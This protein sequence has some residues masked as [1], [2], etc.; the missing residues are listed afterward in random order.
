M[1][2]RALPI[3]NENCLKDVNMKYLQQKLTS[4][5]LKERLIFAILLFLIL[6]FCIVA[7]SYLL[8]P[9]GI[10]KSKNPLS[11]W[12]TSDNTVI[13]TLQI[14]FYNMLSVIVIVLGSLLSYKKESEIRYLSFGYLAFFM[15]VCING[16]VLGTWSFSM[17]NEAAPFL[18]RITGIFDLAHRAGIWEMIGQLFVTCSLAQISM[19]MTSGKTTIKRKIK[20]IHLKNSEKLILITG[21]A[22]MLVGAIIESIAINNL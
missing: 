1:A 12:E 22:L 6:F 13:L 4:N 19:I 7:I 10:L 18:N 16:V 5:N 17:A 21:F 11:N 15:Q 2:D 9:E 14:F 20:D 8:L 3:S